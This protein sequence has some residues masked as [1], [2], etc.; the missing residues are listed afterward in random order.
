[1]SKRSAQRLANCCIVAGYA[2]AAHLIEQL[3]AEESA[4]VCAAIAGKRALSNKEAAEAHALVG[5][6]T[7]EDA[8]RVIA[9]VAPQRS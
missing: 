3:P 4:I 2:F 1:M 6:A 5:K 9:K 8:A 7:A